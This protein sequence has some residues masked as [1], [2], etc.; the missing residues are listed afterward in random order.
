MQKYRGTEND[1][2]Y[3]LLQRRSSA[4]RAGDLYATFN[5]KRHNITKKECKKMHVRTK[6]MACGKIFT[7]VLFKIIDDIVDNNITLRIP[8]YEEKE[9]HIGMEAITGNDFEKMYLRGD[10][11]DLDPVK[12]NFTGYRIYISYKSWNGN[13]HKQLLRISKSWL[14]KITENLNNGKIYY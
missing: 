8:V 13:R 10:F 11:G 12:A 9:A 7:E 1:T 6:S 3:R 14:D 5:F 4:I 2:I